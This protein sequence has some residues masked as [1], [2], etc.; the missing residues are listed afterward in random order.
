MSGRRK[1][2]VVVGGI[3]GATCRELL[4]VLNDYLDGQ[5]DPSICREM[6]RHLRKC[7]PCRVVVDNL[8]KTITLYRQDGARVLPPAF[9]AKLHAELRKAW[10]KRRPAAR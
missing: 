3:G 2:G 7:N 6:E 10:K 5:I 1:K 8:R 4:A 9:R